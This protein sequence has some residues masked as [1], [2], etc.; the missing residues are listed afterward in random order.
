[1]LDPPQLDRGDLHVVVLHKDAPGC[2]APVLLLGAPGGGWHFAG[3]HIPD[4]MG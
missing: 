1:V 4:K 3:Y 2:I